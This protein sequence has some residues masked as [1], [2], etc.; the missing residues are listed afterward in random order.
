MP[1][2][3]AFHPVRLGLGGNE[4]PPQPLAEAGH[5]DTLTKPAALLG[6]VQINA[7][8]CHNEIFG[9]VSANPNTRIR[10]VKTFLFNKNI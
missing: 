1:S 6:W 8:S 9:F 7:G 5:W 10:N 2:N 3:T 4:V